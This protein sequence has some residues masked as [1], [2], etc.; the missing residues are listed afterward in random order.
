MKKYHL[1]TLAQA[2]AFECRAIWRN[3]GEQKD[4]FLL[5]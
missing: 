4:F 1:A 2:R 5:N 3:G